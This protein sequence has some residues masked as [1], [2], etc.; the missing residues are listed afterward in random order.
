MKTIYLNLLKL[1]AKKVLCLLEPEEEVTKPVFSEC[2]H[3][4]HD[5]YWKDSHIILPQED[6]DTVYMK[7]NWNA[8]G[9]TKTMGFLKATFLEPQFKDKFYSCDCVKT[10][11]AGKTQIN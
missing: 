9:K 10:A 11:T 6:T 3:F 7:W 5:S 2:K 8:G 1:L 4:L